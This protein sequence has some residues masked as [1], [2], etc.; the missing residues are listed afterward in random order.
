MGIKR[1]KLAIFLAAIVPVLAAAVLLGFGYYQKYGKGWQ[2]TTP[3]PTPL[4][5]II[6]VKSGELPENLPKDI[7]LENSIQVLQSYY[8]R[9]S[10][11][12]KELTLYQIQSSFSFVSKK[13]PDEN[14]ASY[15][16]YLKTNNWQITG[17][18]DK[19]DVKRLTAIK[20]SDRLSISINVSPLSKE[21]TVGL[22]NIRVGLY[23]EL[24][25]AQ[26]K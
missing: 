22:F 16:K 5:R 18:T 10:P 23:S 26:V 8:T 7:I 3:T 17:S 2:K 1:W 21:T 24:N 9:P 20:G 14:F 4:S 25:K 6:N 19:E 13:E 11:Y 15:S 12:N